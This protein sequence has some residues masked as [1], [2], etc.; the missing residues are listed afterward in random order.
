MFNF[1]PNDFLACNG[2]RQGATHLHQRMV[3]LCDRLKPRLTKLYPDLV[4][5]V[6]PIYTTLDFQ[7]NRNR[8]RDHACL[9]FVD[10][11]LKK[12]AF[13]RLPQLGVYV[14]QNALAIGFYSGWWSQDTMKMVIVDR[15]VFRGLVPRKGYRCLAGDVI[16]ESPDRSVLWS[17]A[18]LDGVDRS[19][20]VGQIYGADD[21]GALDAKIVDGIV[22]VLTDL[23]PLY[24]HF[25]EKRRQIPEATVVYA[26]EPA[27]PSMVRDALAPEEAEL[28]VTLYRFLNLQ[29]FRIAPEM[30]YNVYLCLKTKPFMMLAGISGTGK[31]TVIRLIAEAI[32]GTDQ[33]RALGYRMI[34]V[35]PDWHDVRDL[36]GFENLLTG[37]FR[38][39]ALLQA[40]LAAQA[41]PDRPYFVCLDEMNLARVEHYFADFLSILETARR[42]PDG[43]WTT[44]Q[45]VLAQGREQVEAE[46]LGEMVSQM[47]IPSNLFVVGT[48]NM[49][50]T[51]YAFSPKVLDRA[52]T[53]AFDEVDLG[54]LDSESDVQIDSGQLRDLGLALC[55]RPYRQLEDIRHRTDVMAW[56]ASIEAIND[57]L[58]EE[59]LHFAY[60]IR[61]EMLRYMAYAL[62]LIESLS[63]DAP[64]FTPQDAFDYQILQ[65]I[66]PRLTGTGDEATDVLDA[67]IKFCEGDYVRSAQKLGRMKRRLERTGFVS[68]W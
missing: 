45:V 7:P 3:A 4:P 30:L 41:D 1:S 34:P 39:G 16:V 48:V 43:G 21:V 24:A 61:D 26:T 25:T 55:D 37:K 33:G 42:V 8:P 40:M 17:P 13:P 56:N 65:K 57:I 28:V 52:N 38:P 68:F 58:Q 18:K 46:G 29:G 67:L 32:N 14:H 23:Y 64:S 62:D 35:R 15:K 51:T 49:D 11:K 5:I 50:E 20:F 2:T 10:R 44:D 47:S 12:S 36:L 66:L 19:L 53:V 60:R 54:V 59:N 22:D 6:S 9:Y 31:S 27:D 63:P